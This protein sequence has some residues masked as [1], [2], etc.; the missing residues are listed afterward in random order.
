MRGDDIRIRKLGK[1][2]A[3]PVGQLEVA[4][5]ITITLGQYLS[6]HLP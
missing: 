6:P 5:S 4:V 3:I 2:W 1:E